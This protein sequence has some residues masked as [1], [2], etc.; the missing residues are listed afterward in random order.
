M[1]EKASKLL[2]CVLRA[3]VPSMTRPLKT[4]ITPCMSPRQAQMKLSS[5]FTRESVVSKP[6]GF[7]APVNIIGFTLPWIRYDSAAAE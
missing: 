2:E 5:R 1:D 4:I 6:M 7:C 3:L